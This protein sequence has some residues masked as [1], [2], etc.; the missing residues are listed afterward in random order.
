MSFGVNR[1]MRHN[2]LVTILLVPHTAVGQ[3]E[4][5]VDGGSSAISRPRLD[6]RYQI[7]PQ[8]ADLGRQGVWHG[9]QA[10]FPGAPRRV[11]ALFRQQS[12]K[13]L[14]LCGRLGEHGQQFVHLMQVTQQHDDQRLEK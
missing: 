12:P 2:A 8:T 1:C 5:A 6:Q 11:A 9:F 14:H 4:R 7:A 3:E 13:R 10:S